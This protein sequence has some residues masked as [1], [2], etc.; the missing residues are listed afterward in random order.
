MGFIEIIFGIIRLFQSLLL[1][2]L[3]PLGWF[4]Y[5]D[6]PPCPAGCGLCDIRTGTCL[7]W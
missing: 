1:S 2:F 3:G 5:P 6:A 7:E 4:F